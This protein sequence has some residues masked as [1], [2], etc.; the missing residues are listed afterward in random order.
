MRRFIGLFAILVAVTITV[1]LTMVKKGPSKKEREPQQK[2]QVYTHNISPQVVR[3]VVFG[4]GVV[5]ARWNT[6]LG[7][8][9]SG[10]VI[11]VSDSLLAGTSFSEGEVLAIINPTSY[12][13][14]LA[15]AE[16]ELATALRSYDE[17]QLRVEIAKRNWEVSG[18][19]GEPSD[20]VQRKPQL[21]EAQATINYAQQRVAKAQYDLEQTKITAPYDGVVVER[22]IS[23]GD[24]V[25]VG[26]TLA[27]IYNRE[28]LEVSVPLSRANI[29][30]LE[31]PIIGKQVQL[32]DPLTRRQWRGRISHLDKYI[33]KKNRWQ[34]V[35]VEIMA[36]VDILPGTFVSVELSGQEYDDILIIPENFS[37]QDG[38][39]WFVDSQNILHKV[40]VDVV[41]RKKGNVYIHAPK[42]LSPPHQV[43]TGKDIY[44][45]GTRVTPITDTGELKQAT[46]TTA[47]VF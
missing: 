47:G 36:P 10:R 13:V 29:G 33:D 1:S 19:E 6:T 31:K 4:N 41:Y 9:V 42:T 26:S 28:I 17:E 23:L 5:A 45:S 14:A 25:Q 44:L 3:D 20:L 12:K 34:K 30:R 27:T 40:F 39:I 15:S 38:S 24:I 8:E 43:T 32:T 16:A 46:T 2:L 35:V 11:S 18:M 22:S 21:R 7:S 37:E